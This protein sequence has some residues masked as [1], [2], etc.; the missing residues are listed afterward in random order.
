M[1]TEN[2]INSAELM[3]EEQLDRV[4]GGNDNEIE[5]DDYLLERYGFQ[6]KHFSYNMK[7]SAWDDYC[8]SVIEAWS[9]AGII[10]KYN[11][12][13]ENEYYLKNSDGSITAL[14]HDDAGDYIRRNFE[15]PF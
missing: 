6:K 13:G 15:A 14:S 2:K 8:N 7:A 9:K 5:Y 10:C 11:E 1:T 3:N 12:Y 4:A